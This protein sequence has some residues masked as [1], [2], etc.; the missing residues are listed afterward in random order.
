MTIG[1]S[2]GTKHSFVFA[3]TSGLVNFTKIKTFGVGVGTRLV[4]ILLSC[5]RYHFFLQTSVALFIHLHIHMMKIN[6]IFF[7][8]LEFPY[9]S[10]PPFFLSLLSNFCFAYSESKVTFQD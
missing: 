4:V 3:L 7:A 9:I 10:Q 6:D 2:K 5:T 8:L 1:F